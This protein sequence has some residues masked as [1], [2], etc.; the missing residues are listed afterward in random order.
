[1]GTSIR[2]KANLLIKPT[3]ARRQ[4]DNI[5]KM[6]K[7]QNKTKKTVDQEFYIQQNHAFKMKLK[8]RKFL[9]SR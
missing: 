8:Y 4:W 7:K 6:L 9:A 3:Q 2:L 1:M 5:F